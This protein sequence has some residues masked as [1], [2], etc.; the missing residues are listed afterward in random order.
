M[1]I[2]LKSFLH[3]IAITLCPGIY[4]HDIYV[5]A[6]GND[7]SPG[8][9]EKPIA[10]LAKAKELA[11]QYDRDQS[12][13]VIFAD[14]VYYLPQ[15][16]VFSE[17]DSKTLPAR[18]TYKAENEG[19]AVL[20]GGELLRLEWKPSNK[21][22]FVAP[23]GK[24]IVIDQ[25]YVNGERQRMA[26]FPNADPGDGKNVFDTWKLSHNA[27]ADELQDPLDLERIATWKNPAGG[28]LH[29]MQANLWG[30]R[31][32]L[33]TG[34]NSD[35]TLA[36]EGGWQNNRP[37]SIHATYRIVENI[38]EELDAPGEW[39]FDAEK[40]EL[41]YMPQP[42]TNMETA[43]IEIVQLKH[44]IEFNGSK[45]RPV[46]GVDLKG[47]V[48]RH[49][50]RTF[51]ENKEPL[52]RSDWTVYRG[53]TVVYNGATD[54]LME[55][56][57]FDQVGGNA[58]FVNNYNRR[59]TIK[60]CHIH[61]SGANGVAFVG[62]PASVR[63]P[64]F[65]YGK[66]NYA[67]LDRTPGPKGDNYPADCVVEDCLITM[68]GRVEKQ[69]APV[70]I[71]MSHRIR[72][73]HCSI[74]DVPRAG[75]NISEGTFGGHTIEYCDVFNT[76]LE[77][78][79]HGSFNSWGRDRFWT[80]DVNEFSKQVAQEPEMPYW[81][82]LDPTVIR[83]SR[84]RCDHGWDI[85]LD[86]GSTRYRIY[87]NLLLNGGL[88]LREGYDRIVKNNIIVNNSLH[89]HIWPANSGDVFTHNI[90]F[91]AYR[92]A[93]MGVNIPPDGKWG[94]ELDF[95]LFVSDAASM[96]KFSANGT[97]RNSVTG[98]PMFLHAAAGDFRVADS[99][100]AIKVGFRN[101]PMN[102]FG[103]KSP[104]LKRIAKTPTLPNVVINLGKKDEKRESRYTWMG[105]ELKEPKEDEF[106]AYG[107][108]FED[109]GVALGVITENSSMHK[110][111]FRSGDLIQ[112]INGTPITKLSDLLKYAQSGLG[113]GKPQK[114]TLVRNQEQMHI[115]IPEIREAPI[116]H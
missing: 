56:C 55:N 112:Q 29:A 30:G 70:Q 52:L 109:A 21:G 49:A 13:D 10:T 91:G 79:D 38:L 106:S 14:G 42:S 90:V 50:S 72:V 68:T 27:K 46:T 82:I 87:N 74:Y 58:V 111:G 1:N 84:W 51:M 3:I 88:K 65:R 115:T 94:K 114:V 22:Q 26:R 108:K 80:P 54:C 96:R 77:T 110:A 86:D 23:I 59:V 105:I 60:G 5:S 48:F 32:W 83:N 39:Y 16:V 41:H 19:G 102:Q 6:K 104:R 103:V 71:S 78:G 81:D 18:V 43:K 47:F 76:V 95:N 101:F 61:H 98:D 15:T 37:S 100:P 97:D 33:I 11:R 20:S 66:Q 75:I 4:A 69:T 53:G 92:P 9:K 67:E 31:H 24:D 63:S 34:K 89:P 8:T 85:D 93:V 2:I 45:E 107:V 73:S 40:G 28:Y 12:V 17:A 113:S 35:G 116:A 25:L 57:E 44:L 7:S 64:L 62:D 36:M 99:S